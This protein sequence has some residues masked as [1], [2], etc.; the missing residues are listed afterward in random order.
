[1]TISDPGGFPAVKQC[2]ILKVKAENRTYLNEVN[3]RKPSVV[4]ITQRGEI[5]FH[6]DRNKRDRTVSISERGEGQRWFCAKAW[7]CFLENSL[8]L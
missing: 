3:V 1:V 5:L 2:L 6:K 8:S 4:S 7:P